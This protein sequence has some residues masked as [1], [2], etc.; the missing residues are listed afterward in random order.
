VGG[1]AGLDAVEKRESLGPTRNRTSA[2]QQMKTEKE[3]EN[4][5]DETKMKERIER[6]REENNIV[7]SI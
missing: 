6:K 3:E 5:E 4:E 1:R 2:V 7:L